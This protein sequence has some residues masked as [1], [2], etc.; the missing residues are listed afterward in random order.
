MT[1]KQPKQKCKR[2]VAFVL[3]V[4]EVVNGLLLLSGFLIFGLSALS[5]LTQILKDPGE[6]GGTT[7]WTGK[8]RQKRGN[9][10]PAQSL[11]AS[12]SPLVSGPLT[13]EETV[14]HSLFMAFSL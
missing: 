10:C 6:G 9:I 4:W 1:T 13:N 5:S 11:S 14:N 2:Y 7:I 12:I 8:H 3:I